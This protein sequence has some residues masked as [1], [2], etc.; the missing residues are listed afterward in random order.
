MTVMIPRCSPVGSHLGDSSCFFGALVILRMR[1]Q[2]KEGA[3]CLFKHKPHDHR[4]PN[5][6]SQQQLAYS[7]TLR[8]KEL[9]F[10]ALCGINYFLVGF[11][12]ERERE[13]HA[14][15][16]IFFKDF[17]CWIV[18]LYF[19]IICNLDLIRCGIFVL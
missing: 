15:Y 17:T 7:T 18:M 14:R 4:V 16:I 8:V 12:G 11:D 9:S 3:A 13:R 19:I 2:E 10:C 6:F 5:A 1:S